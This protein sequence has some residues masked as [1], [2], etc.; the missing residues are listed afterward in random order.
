M[1]KRKNEVPIEKVYE[2]WSAIADSRIEI[3]P[4]SDV[5]KGNA[6]VLSSSGEKKYKV[7]WRDRGHIF[8]SDDNATFWRGYPGYSVIA[9]LMILERIPLDE[10]I[11]SKFA[12]INWNEIN[13]RHRGKYAEA[14]AEVE[15]E[16]GLDPEQCVQ[17]AQ[18]AYD[19]LGKLGLEIKRV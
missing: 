15:Q 11:A 6:R 2:A 17:A 13:R 16:R 1:E 5:N 7:T 12:G 3:D 9:V 8:T 14:L 18:K 19:A 4:D 10:D